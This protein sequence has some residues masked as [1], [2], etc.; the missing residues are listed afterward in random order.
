MA[1]E[2]CEQVSQSLECAGGH[3]GRPVCPSSCPQEFQVFRDVLESTAKLVRVTATT[4]QRSLCT[5]QTHRYTEPGTSIPLSPARANGA[6]S[7]LG[8]PSKPQLRTLQWTGYQTGPGETSW[9]C[10][11]C[12]PSPPSPLTLWSTSQNS[13]LSSTARSPTGELGP[14]AWQGGHIEGVRPQRQEQPKVALRLWPHLFHALGPI[15]PDTPLSSVIQPAESLWP[16]PSHRSSFRET[17]ALLQGT[18]AWHLGQ[19]PGPVPEAAGPALPAWRQGYQRHAGFC[20]R[21]PGATLH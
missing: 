9:H 18:I 17:W 2:S 1:Q 19:V 20:G 15:S 3:R 4:A 21:Q 11:T 16:V 13:G 8:V 7:C 5:G 14:K 10:R 12:K 6:T